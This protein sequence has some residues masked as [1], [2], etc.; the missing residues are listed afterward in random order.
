MPLKHVWLNP[1]HEGDMQSLSLESKS[2]EP[3]Q[4]INVSE[5]AFPET[6]SDAEKR[7]TINL[8]YFTNNEL[9]MIATTLCYFLLGE[10]DY[11]KDTINEL[12]KDFKQRG[13]KTGRIHRKQT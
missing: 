2:N 10:T 8:G 4:R 12:V 1:S 11:K 3:G 5:Q 6:Q 13:A 7:H 9:A